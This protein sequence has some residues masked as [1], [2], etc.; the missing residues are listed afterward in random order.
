MNDM[1]RRKF[2][3]SL[4]EAFKG[5]EASPSE[6]VWTNIE[7]DLEKAEGG[8]MKRRLLFFKMLAAAS[9][10][11]AMCIV[12]IGYYAFNGK[13]QQGNIAQ[14][15]NS[16]TETTDAV[17]NN[18]KTL[19]EDAALENSKTQ[20]NKKELT[21]EAL[22]LSET[23]NENITEKNDVVL[24]DNPKTKTI[25]QAL[26]SKELKSSDVKDNSE[27][28]NKKSGKEDTNSLASGS[29]NND[30]NKNAI[31]NASEI[32]T[33]K[34]L[35]N[36]SI[37]NNLKNT[38]TSPE[39]RELIEKNTSS[40]SKPEIKNRAETPRQLPAFYQPKAPELR[41][42][43]SE[44]DPGAML[45][46]KLA[47]KEMEYANEDKRQEKNKSEKLW[48][49]VG[50]AAGGFNS[51]NPS[52]TPTPSNSYSSSSSSPTSVA[53]KQSKASG[54]AYSVGFSVGAKLSDRWIL[55]GG[56]NY[57]TQSSDYTANNVIVDNNLQS[58]RAESINSF[59]SDQALAS[60][61]SSQRVAQTFPYSVNNN[62]QFISLPV[63]TG[64]LVVNRKF[65]F[66]VN[67][68]VSTDLFLQNTITPEGGGIDKTTQGRGDDS[69]YR[70]LNFSGLM[71]TEL[72]YKFG[73]RY[74]LSLNP[75]LRYP[76]SSVYKSSTGVQA[77]PLTFDV[78]LRFRYI[79]H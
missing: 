30:E 45:L 25:E 26:A 74:R 17:K 13:T 19:R 21:N 16:G 44:P 79:F 58:P 62:V 76:F 6:N 36:T 75:G 40:L 61:E 67:A 49:S 20:T 29:K 10:V 72:S 69:P 38:T 1:E 46:A 35:T 55:Q 4:Q 18:D 65:G 5:A 7:L 11:F 41:L 71:G 66:Q 12:G 33:K 2:E 15:I 50:F 51:L 78:G 23:T 43:V 39:G 28:Q 70:S 53:A 52:V 48:T 73:S 37:G 47:A 9:I 8:K 34:S 68:G 32:L 77:N 56:F 22:E 57:L 31:A 27:S 54:V 3:D 14:K 59:K 60:D 63:Q 24:E 42:A 64:Y